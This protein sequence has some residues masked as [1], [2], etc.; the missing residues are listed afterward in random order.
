MAI[1][2]RQEVVYGLYQV[3]NPTIII[4]LFL[5]NKIYFTQNATSMAIYFR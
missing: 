3:V 5:F 4:M 2:F 1:Y